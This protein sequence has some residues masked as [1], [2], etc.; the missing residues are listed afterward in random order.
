M[1]KNMSYLVDSDLDLSSDDAN[2]VEIGILHSWEI[3]TSDSDSGEDP[4][5]CHIPEKA[6]EKIELWIFLP[7][8]V[9]GTTL[10]IHG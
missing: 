3:Y 9:E 8:A 1:E 2:L 6:D 5:P 10:M 4:P 7:C